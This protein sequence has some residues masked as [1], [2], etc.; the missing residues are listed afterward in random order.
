MT[1]ADIDGSGTIDFGEFTEFL[2]KLS[3]DSTEDELKQVFDQIDEDK[4]GE[5]DLEEFGKAIYE[6]LKPGDDAE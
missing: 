1:I 5:L 3:P 6:C 4:S 2:N